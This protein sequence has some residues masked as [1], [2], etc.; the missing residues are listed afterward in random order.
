MLNE[1]NLLKKK[2]EVFE[3]KF[4]SKDQPIKHEENKLDKFI[5]IIF[6]YAINYFKFSFK[7]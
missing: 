4:Y 5:G 6:S 7:L 1:L 3:L 2:I